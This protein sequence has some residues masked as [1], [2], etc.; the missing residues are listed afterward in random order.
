MATPLPVPVLLIGSSADFGLS[1]IQSVLQ[2]LGYQHDMLLYAEH[3]RSAQDRIIEHL[4]NLIL[5]LV[6]QA[7][8]LHAIPQIK[9]YNHSTPV[10]ALLHADT[11]ALI[12]TAI[13]CGANS[14]MQQQ[15]SL[16][17]FSESLKIVLRG[18]AYIHAEL[19]GYILQQLSDKTCLNVAELQLLQ[20]FSQQKMPAEIQHQLQLPEYQLYAKVKQIY[21]KLLMSSD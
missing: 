2:H 15:D 7:S 10:V 14:Y 21:Q 17:Q 12:Y 19:A 3:I 5:Y 18:G 8:A 11:P 16:L 9:Q 4:P 20:L 13:L 1:K 6:N